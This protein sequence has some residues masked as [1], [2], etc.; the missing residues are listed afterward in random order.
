VKIRSVKA[1]KRRSAFE[2]TASGK[3][4]TFP[5]ARLDPRPMPDD[6]LVKVFVDPELGAE[7][8]TYV[9]KSGREGTVHVEDV[10][11]Y[12]QDPNYLR[13]LLLYRLTLEAQKRVAATP[14][15]K[16]ELI[17]R[18]KSTH[19][20]FPTGRRAARRERRAA[21]DQD[22]RSVCGSVTVPGFSSAARVAQSKYA[23]GSTPESLADSMRL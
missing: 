7:G 9:L 17:R 5:F 22:V 2:V 21:F 11:E 3:R 20:R 10:L 14:L 23:F 16:R 8:F 4:L 12:N 13:D 18:L 6:P 15:A 1:N 19:S